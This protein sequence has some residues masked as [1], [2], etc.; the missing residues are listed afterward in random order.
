MY[1]KVS[2]FSKNKQFKEKSVPKKNE[3]EC[4][5]EIKKIKIMNIYVLLLVVSSIVLA[6]ASP[7]MESAI[8]TAPA[9]TH[10]GSNVIRRTKR[11]PNGRCPKDNG[12]SDEWLNWPR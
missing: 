7:Y 12:D 5:E 10:F 11:C 6:V 9:N 8:G 1:I 3:D 2:T 4:Q